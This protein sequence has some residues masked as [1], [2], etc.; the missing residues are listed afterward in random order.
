M[1]R[2][3]HELHRQE[4][5]K[6]T[7]R[8]SRS[9]A[10]DFRAPLRAPLFSLDTKSSSAGPIGV[11]HAH[12]QQVRTEQ[13]QGGSSSKPSWNSELNRSCGKS[14]RKQSQAGRAGHDDGTGIIQTS[15]YRITV[16][17]HSEHA[18]DTDRSKPDVGGPMR[19]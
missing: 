17:T 3:R 8:R 10:M 11:P 9:L 6:S 19:F 5:C 4:R 15:L 2:T 12:H 14:R 13:C 1:R 16:N 7:R 18:E